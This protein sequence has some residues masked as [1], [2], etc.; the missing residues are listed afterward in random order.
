MIETVVLNFDPTT[1]DNDDIRAIFQ[2]PLATQFYL[3][4][5][6]DHIVGPEFE[7]NVLAVANLLRGTKMM[8]PEEL[9]KRVWFAVKADSGNFTEGDVIKFC[10]DFWSYYKGEKIVQYAVSH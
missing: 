10:V 2:D 7:K 9:R 6:K 3:L 1:S 4:W 5:R 8:Y